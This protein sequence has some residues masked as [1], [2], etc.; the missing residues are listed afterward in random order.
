MFSKCLAFFIDMLRFSR[1]EPDF[2]KEIGVRLNTLEP[3]FDKELGL[4]CFL[5]LDIFRMYMFF[6][7]IISCINAEYKK[8]VNGVR[9]LLSLIISW[10]LSLSKILNLSRMLFLVSPKVQ[11]VSINIFLFS[12]SLYTVTKVASIVLLELNLPIFMTSR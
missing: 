2:D 3:D 11:S 4:C 5:D 9:L 6:S 7:A 1:L 12:N 8:S 10:Y